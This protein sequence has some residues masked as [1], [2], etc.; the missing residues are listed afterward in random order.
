MMEP[1]FYWVRFVPDWSNAQSEWEPARF[2]GS[3]DDGSANELPWTL[4]G[5]DKSYPHD[6]VEVGPR[7]HPP[8]SSDAINAGDAA[9]ASLH[10]EAPTQAEA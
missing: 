10:A 8:E 3:C 1:G 6:G 2:D 5:C 7:M 9:M 4:L